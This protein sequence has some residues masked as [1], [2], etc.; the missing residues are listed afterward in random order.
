MDHM[1]TEGWFR[2]RLTMVSRSAIAEGAL[3]NQRVSSM[4]R[5]PFRSIS[6][7]QYSACG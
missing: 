6:S 3:L 1:N 7:I 4:T 2:S 5:M